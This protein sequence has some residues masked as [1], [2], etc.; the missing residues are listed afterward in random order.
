MQLFAFFIDGT[1]RHFSYFDHL[2]QD[3]AYARTIESD[4]AALVSSHTVKRFFQAFSWPLIWSFRGILLKIFIWR[5]SITKSELVEK[6]IDI[7]ARIVKRS[8][9]FVLKVSQAIFTALDFV[10]LWARS[11]NPPRLLME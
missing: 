10:N 3:E 5:L 6:V 8:R 4:P 1:S 2:K 7:G 11:N 9:E